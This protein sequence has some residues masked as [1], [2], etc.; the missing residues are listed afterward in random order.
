MAHSSAWAVIDKSGHTHYAIVLSHMEKVQAK[1]RTAQEKAKHIRRAGNIPAVLYGHKVQNVNLMLD[2]KLFTKLYKSAGETT[3]VNVSIEGETAP[4]SALIH[5]VSVDPVN[6]SI[7]HVDFYEIKKDQKISTHIP[8]VFK[9]E[10]DAVKS[11]GGVLVK[12]MHK[13]EIEALSQDLPHEIVVDI[14]LLKTLND[15]IALGD[16]AIPPGVKV[17]GDLKD[18]VVKVMPP[19]TEAELESLKEEAVMKVEE[20]KVETEEKKKER[21]AAKAAEKEAKE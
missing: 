9:G 5:D 20:V 8:L 21:D 16:L 18:I 14:S 17:R 6:G 12:N 3:V 10:S 11:F 2:A 19:R 15:A 4:R 1:T 13:I 7:H